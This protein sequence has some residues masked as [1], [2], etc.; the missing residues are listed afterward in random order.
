MGVPS[1][2]ARSISL[3]PASSSSNRTSAQFSKDILA[4]EYLAATKLTTATELS[5]GS[6]RS[7][8]QSTYC[9]SESV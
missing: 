4:L 1:Q 8:S 6:A 9:I 5:A 2:S 3:R 7:D